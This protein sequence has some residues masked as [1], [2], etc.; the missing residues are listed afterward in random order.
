MPGLARHLAYTQINWIALKL[1]N[2]SYTFKAAFL[3]ND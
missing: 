1:F 3:F 2:G